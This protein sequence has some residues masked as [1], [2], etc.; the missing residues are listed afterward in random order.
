MAAAIRAQQEDLR[1]RRDYIEKIL[2]NATT[3]VVSFD[4]AGRVVTVN[5]AARLL[6]GAPLDTGT[7]LGA[8]LKGAGLARLAALLPAAPVGDFAERREEAALV[9]D[10]DERRL[11]AVLVP[12]RDQEQTAGG[13]LLVEDIT[14]NVRSDRLRAWAEMAQRI[15][16][17]IKN[18]L[19]PIQLS[20][21]HLRH[22]FRDRPPDFER[23]LDDCLRTITG[24]VRELRTL[25]RE[26]STFARIPEL[27]LERVDLRDVLDGALAPYR[28]AAPADLRIE[29]RWQDRPVAVRVDQNLLRRALVNLLENSIE[30]LEGR[31]TIRVDL[32]ELSNDG[33]RQACIVVEDDGPGIDPAILPRLFEPFFSTKGSGT[34]LGLAIARQAV[35][36]NG[37]TIAVDRPA[38][39][40]GTRMTILIPTAEA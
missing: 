3:G 2:L 8:A 33:R 38:S 5:P 30:A 19:T 18:P 11:R 12:L 25:A 10:G 4:A 1:A 37:G 14:E 32:A 29:S 26:F 17:E 40:R 16:H 24:Q 15:A 21:E 39:G 27:K 31:G 35:E 13:L 23:V 20:A 22:V 34:G 9:K 6:T 36:A 28:S 7:D